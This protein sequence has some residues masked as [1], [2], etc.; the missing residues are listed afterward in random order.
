MSA[1]K[2]TTPASSA[3]VSLAETKAFLEIAADDTSFDSL[4][5]ELIAEKTKE[6][7]DLMARAL[8]TRTLKWYLDDWN[9]NADR[10]IE[11]PVAPVQSSGFSIEYYNSENVLTTWSSA[12]YELDVISEP[13]RIRPKSGYSYP[14]VYDRLNAIAI[15]FKAGK[16]SPTEIESDIKGAIK[17]LIANRFRFREDESIGAQVTDKEAAFKVLNGYRLRYFA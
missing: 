9:A 1:P 8:V 2:V 4:L 11:I 17:V 5:L 12:E 10:I 3:P 16:D 13:A 14:E 15:T 6:A 7:E